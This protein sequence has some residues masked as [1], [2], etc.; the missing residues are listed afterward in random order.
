MNTECGRFSRR[1]PA[2]TQS[3]FLCEG[4]AQV[5]RPA[6]RAPARTGTFSKLKL[7]LQRWY[8]SAVKGP[9]KAGFYV[10][11][12][13]FSGAHLPLHPLV[14]RHLLFPNQFIRLAYDSPCSRGPT[15][16]PG[17]RQLPMHRRQFPNVELPS[18]QSGLILIMFLG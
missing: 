18:R 8:N 3:V 11:S 2:T 16:Q 13:L 15:L 10:L 9:Q 5:M 14:W 6:K 7:M 12:N 1:A 4:R 17:R